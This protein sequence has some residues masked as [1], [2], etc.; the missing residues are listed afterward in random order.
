MSQ[1]ITLPRLCR[2]FG[3]SDVTGRRYLADYKGSADRGTRRWNFFRIEELPD[4][5]AHIQSKRRR[6]CR[7]KYNSSLESK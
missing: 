3:I 2:E 7:N 6:H 4:I 5:E 1:L